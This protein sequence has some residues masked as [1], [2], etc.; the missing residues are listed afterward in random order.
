MTYKMKCENHRESVDELLQYLPL[1]GSEDRAVLDADISLEE[2]TAAVGQM[3]AGR[4]PG[5]D[6]LPTDFYKRFWEC[7]GADLW[8]VLN[9]C[10]GSGAERHQAGMF[11]MRLAI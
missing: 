8:E 7:L 11:H 3:A 5:L 1:L 4:A 2:L 10:S 9:E 6:G